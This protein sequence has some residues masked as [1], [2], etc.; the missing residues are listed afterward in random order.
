MEQGSPEWLKWRSQGIGGSDVACLMGDLTY[1]T[2]YKLWLEKTGKQKS[3][4][5][6]SRTAFARG[7]ENEKRIRA[8][9][10]FEKGADYPPTE[11]ESPD[12][13]EVRV[14]LDGFC[15]AQWRGCEIKLVGK[16]VFEGKIIK[17]GHWIQM[18]YQMLATKAPEWDYVMSDDGVRYHIELVL[19]D[20]EFQREMLNKTLWFWGMVKNGT[21][22][23]YTEMDWIPVENEVLEALLDCVKSFKDSKI[24]SE[25]D[26][27][28][29]W[30]D[31]VFGMVKNQ[32]TI[33]AG[34]KI[35]KTEKMRSIKFEEAAD[36]AKGKDES[37]AAAVPAEKAGQDQTGGDGPSPG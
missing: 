33:C 2:P 28:A 12:H 23:P 9:Y 15:E 36:V 18:Q 27:L 21:P 35:L 22:P 17:R 29:V 11:F 34:A 26:Q 16:D 14:S 20:A 5:W 31:E 7:H 6:D 32:R 37:Q 25:K 10:E 8:A 13:P 3:D 24:K 19:A 1:T 30:R 4:D